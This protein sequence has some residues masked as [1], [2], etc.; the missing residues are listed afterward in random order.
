MERFILTKLDRNYEKKSC[1][2]PLPTKLSQIYITPS[3]VEGEDPGG[4]NGTPPGDEFQQGEEPPIVGVSAILAKS[5]RVSK[6]SNE[7]RVCAGFAE[8]DR[9]LKPSKFPSQAGHESQMD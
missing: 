9:V 1:K 2:I 7:V 5:D 4:E 8:S 6:P 3:L